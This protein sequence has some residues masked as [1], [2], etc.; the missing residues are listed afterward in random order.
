MLMSVIPAV[1]RA[2]PKQANARLIDKGKEM[3][4]AP[5][6]YLLLIGAVALAG[7]TSPCDIDTIKSA[8]QSGD[9]SEVTMKAIDGCL[10]Y[11]EKNQIA[12]SPIVCD[13]SQDC[14]CRDNPAASMLSRLTNFLARTAIQEIGN[15]PSTYCCN[16]DTCAALCFCANT[17]E[18][19]KAGVVESSNAACFCPSGKDDTGKCSNGGVGQPH[20]PALIDSDDPKAIIKNLTNRLLTL[21]QNAI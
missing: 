5:L 12:Q 8:N 1:V 3:K 4:Y 6:L 15:A 11:L 21:N 20:A 18:C 13:Q 2:L 16:I 14:L 7:Q 19:K 17:D 10:A 9:T